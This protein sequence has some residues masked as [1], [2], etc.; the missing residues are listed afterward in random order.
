VGVLIFSYPD[1]GFSVL[2]PQLWG[3]CQGI[4]RKDWARPTLF[5]TVIRDVLLLIVMF[6]V[7]SVCKC[8]LPP[9]VNP[10]AVDK[11]IDINISISVYQYHYIN[12]NISVSIMTLSLLVDLVTSLWRLFLVTVR[13]GTARRRSCWRWR[14]RWIWN[15]ELGVSGSYL[16]LSFQQ[17]YQLM[18]QKY[19]RKINFFKRR[20]L[21]TVTNCCRAIS[22]S[23]CIATKVGLG[24]DVNW[25]HCVPDNCE[26]YLQL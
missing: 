26:W 16:L 14:K 12:I 3:K 2:F 9:G 8:V 1:W 21:S 18:K 25:M 10:I 4:I 23:A 6:Y 19:T 24:F 15:L 13:H 5:Q 22:A 11:Y 20:W 17:Y 7:L